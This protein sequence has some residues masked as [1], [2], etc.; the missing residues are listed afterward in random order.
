MIII[1]D[2]DSVAMQQCGK[3]ECRFFFVFFVFFFFGYGMDCDEPRSRDAERADC[4]IAVVHPVLYPKKKK[5][6]TS[7]FA[8]RPQ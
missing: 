8:T 3:G 5:K 1:I 2:C 6:T 7:A 4:Q